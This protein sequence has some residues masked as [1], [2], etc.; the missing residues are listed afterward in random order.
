[1][2]VDE[3]YKRVED[4]QPYEIYQDAYFRLVRLPP[5]GAKVHQ[6]N[7]LQHSFLLL[8]KL[9][10]RGK[11]PAEETFRES[12]ERDPFQCRQGLQELVTAIEEFEICV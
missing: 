7:S 2:D 5:N 10:D 3:L 4:R 12:M 8:I 6:L 9:Y 11:I 1:M